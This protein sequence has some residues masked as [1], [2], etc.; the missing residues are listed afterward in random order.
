MEP[1]D[2]PAV[3]RARVA[4]RADAESV[5]VPAVRGGVD[6]GSDAAATAAEEGDRGRGGG[7]HGDGRREAGPRGDEGGVPAEG[8]ALPDVFVDE[9]KDEGGREEEESCGGGRGR[10]R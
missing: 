7:P 10:G 8:S 1:R 9:W 2:R 6:R 5:R 3:H 4:V